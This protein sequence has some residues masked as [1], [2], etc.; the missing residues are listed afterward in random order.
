MNLVNDFKQKYNL[1]SDAEKAEER[2]ALDK[3]NQE[4]K[5][6]FVDEALMLK[7]KMNSSGVNKNAIDSLYLKYRKSELTNELSLDKP[8][9]RWV[10]T[11]LFAVFGSIVF[12][13]IFSALID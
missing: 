6:G 13:S 9:I 12:I 3:L 11:I 2:I 7:A 8:K 5:E 10:Q 1:Q 4:Q